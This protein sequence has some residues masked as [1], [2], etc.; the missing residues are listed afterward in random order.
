MGLAYL[1]SG[2]LLLPLSLQLSGQ[3]G[4]GLGLPG[5]LPLLRSL[6]QVP[7]A[8]QGQAERRR[9]SGREQ[10]GEDEGRRED[11]RG[12]REETAPPF[13][14]HPCQSFSLTRGM[15]QG[16]NAQQEP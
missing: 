7:L 1:D 6:A 12:E 2:S 16:W 14:W 9:S 4:V 8:A 13:V 11:G 10:E 5:L 3:S 15:S